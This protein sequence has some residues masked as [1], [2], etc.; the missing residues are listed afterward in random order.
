[1]VI[2]PSSIRENAKLEKDQTT[3][4]QRWRHKLDATDELEK[5][6]HDMQ[7]GD[8]WSRAKVLVSNMRSRF[9]NGARIAGEKMRPVLET[10]EELDLYY[11]RI[12]E[13]TDVE[14]SRHDIGNPRENEDDEVK[15]ILI[16][17]CLYDKKFH[18]F[19]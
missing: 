17:N 2:A 6:Y 5:A 9:R 18:T 15:E 10:H 19:Y 3:F 13:L 16:Q 8:D 11:I 12:E 7:L 4:R 1:M 14:E